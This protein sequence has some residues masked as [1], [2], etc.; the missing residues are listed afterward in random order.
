MKTYGFWLLLVLLPINSNAQLG[1]D[2]GIKLSSNQ[3]NR[4]QLEQRFH[5]EDKVTFLMNFGYNR[6]STHPREY[7]WDDYHTSALIIEHV[8]IDFFQFKIGLQRV[9]VSNRNSSIYTGFSGGINIQ[10]TK[11]YHAY[12]ELSYEFDPYD[13]T[14]NYDLVYK[15]PKS[16]RK[17]EYI[18]SST[19]KEVTGDIFIGLDYRLF[20]SPLFFT[21]AV[22]GYMD[23]IY[24][25]E[26]FHYKPY[27]FGLEFNAGFRYVIRE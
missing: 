25:S 12:A 23:Y 21:G 2:I 3:A 24:K 13:T 9:I 11:K 4:F 27:H 18:G 8:L 22:H 10:E 26:L 1:Y 6:W 15:Y 20:E 17:M 5:F 14:G 7:F 16:V 19:V